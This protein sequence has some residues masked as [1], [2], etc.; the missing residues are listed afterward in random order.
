MSINQFSKMNRFIKR[1]IVGYFAPAIAVRRIYKKRQWKY[2]HQM[3]VI[4]RYTFGR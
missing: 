2:R 1:S 4:Y 3:R